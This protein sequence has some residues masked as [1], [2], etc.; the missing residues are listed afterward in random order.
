MRS[1]LPEESV[2]YDLP[3]RDLMQD[4][5]AIAGYSNKKR[6]LEVQIEPLGEAIFLPSRETSPAVLG[7]AE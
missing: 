4:I 3:A 2:Y 1:V 5:T 6:G 7:C